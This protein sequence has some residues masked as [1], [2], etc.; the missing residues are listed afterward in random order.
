MRRG[1][2]KIYS[3]E[4]FYNLRKLWQLMGEMGSKKMKAAL[5]EWIGFYEA[6][7]F[8]ESIKAELL[9]MSP[10]T[11]DRNLK[12]FKVVA[13]RKRQTGTKPGNP[14]LKKIIPLKTFDWMVTEPGHTEMDTVAHCGFSMTGIFAWTLTV[15]DVLS[16]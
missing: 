2:K 5:P 10:A 16:G 14:L 15:T 7:D 12:I 3:Q 1:R 11:M 8:S 13:K 9:K 6:E 4:A